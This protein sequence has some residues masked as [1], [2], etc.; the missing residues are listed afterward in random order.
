MEEQSL[1]YKTLR[2]SSYLFLGFVLSMIFTIFVTRQLSQKLGTTE[3][4]IYL[5]VN[6]ISAFVGFVDLGLSTAIAKY[7]AEYQA[8]GD[9]QA[10]RNILSSARVI[11]V[12]TGS[13][14]LLV[15]LII[16]RWFLPAFH[17]PAESLNNIFLVF[18]LAGLVFFLNSIASVYIAALT[19]LQRFDII[20]RLNLSNLVFV[21][22]GAI[23]LLVMG[24]QLKAVMA[25][26]VAATFL[27]LLFSRHFSHKVL[28]ELNLGFVM[29]KSE[30]VKA[31]KF[32]LLTFISNLAGSC[33]IYF[34]RL[35]IPIFLGPSQLAF[36]SVP[37]NVALKTA[38]ITN[39]LAGMLFPM[40]S[41]FSGSGNMEQFKQIYVRAFR[42]LSIVAVAVTVAIILFA[43]KILLFWLG[44]E[45]AQYGTKILVILAFTYYLVSLFIPLQS[46]LLGL[47]K[48][49]FL[50]A[51]SSFMAVLNLILLLI[52]VPKFGIVGAAWAYLISVLPM[53]F[54]F[55]WAEKHIFQ[56]SGQFSVYL[57]LYIRLLFTALVDVFLIYFLLL[58]LA[59]NVWS[60]VVI[61]PLSVLL[62]FALY[63]IFRFVDPEDE[64]LFKSFV[65]KFLKFKKS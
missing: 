13:L 15:F 12:F 36:Y 45:F 16:G 52:L 1:S 43:N 64:Q 62:Y 53:I 42:N 34:D 61:G 35:L 31:Y 8:R 63:Y 41:A 48:L 65:M 32:G 4:G 23:A 49:K 11:F 25:L 39:S 20:T 50:I 38:T 30:I 9:L 46:I 2:N 55:Y 27:L 22:L 24:F 60:L 33:L 14:G 10:L 7:V 56:L 5:L 51:Q 17:V 21:S 6:T 59:K 29:V 57:R 58:P 44:P 3:F 40:A 28:P 19:A 47:G 37:G 18:S 54:A 26:N